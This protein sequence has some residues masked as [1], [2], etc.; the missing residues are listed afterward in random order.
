M[1]TQLSIFDTLQPLDTAPHKV[2]AGDWIRLLR[3][4]PHAAYW[5]KGEV[6][7]VEGVHPTQGTARFWNERANDWAYIHPGD[8]VKVSA[9][10]DTVLPG[11]IAPVEELPPVPDTVDSVSMP[12]L[13][14]TESAEIPTRFDTESNYPHSETVINPGV[15]ADTESNCQHGEFDSVS[16]P[17][18]TYRA[19]GTARSG[20]YFRFSYRAGKKMKHL[21]IP[22]GNTGNVLAQ[23]RAAEVM[24]LAAAGVPAVE[25]CDRIRS[26]SGRITW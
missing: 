12:A 22:G 2:K 16:G 9:P 8:M 25:I 15:E 7:Q 10:I 24:E 11:A 14:D 13:A 17:V 18:A 5:K 21:H 3:K 6:V 19:R 23:S 4:T 20:E 1:Q 26:W